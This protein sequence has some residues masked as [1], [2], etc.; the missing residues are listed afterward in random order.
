M[1]TA[2]AIFFVVCAIFLFILS[3]QAELTKEGIPHH[4]HAAG[5][6]G[7]DARYGHGLK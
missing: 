7:T 5:N 6:S 2:V 3:L 4:K 1:R